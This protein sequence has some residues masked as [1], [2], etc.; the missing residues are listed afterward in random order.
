MLTMQAIIDLQRRF[1]EEGDEALLRP[2]ILKDVAERT[3]LDLSTIS[4]VSN[5]KYA[6]TRWGTF[7]L[8]F[9]FSDG[10]MT[11]SGEELSQ[12]EIKVALREL[13]DSEDKLRPLSDEVLSAKL[14]QRGYPIARRT[15]AKYR[16]QMN[17]P[18]ARLRK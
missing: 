13:I 4:R 2:M 10:V 6:Q 3:G 1:F 17:I 7:P 8:K 12:R 18:V 14:K 16:E 11:E 9:F 5:S 15:V